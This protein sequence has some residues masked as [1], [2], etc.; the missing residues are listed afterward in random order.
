MYPLETINDRAWYAWQCLPRKRTKKGALGKPP[1]YRSLERDYDISPATL[2][3]LFSGDR[4]TVELGT[5]PKLAAALRVTERWLMHGEGQPPEL[6]GPYKPREDKFADHDPATW[7]QLATT[8]D[9]D[10]DVTRL[11]E[12]N[13]FTQ[14]VQKLRKTLKLNQTIVNRTR[15]KHAKQW[16]NGYEMVGWLLLL[17]EE[18]KQWVRENDGAEVVEDFND[19][20]DLTSRVS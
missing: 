8:E 16:P 6:T 9:G 11:L 13:N 12:Q 3:K 14:A 19:D 17:A 1:S 15:A 5:I 18:R 4:K 10:I 7:V 2:S 20:E